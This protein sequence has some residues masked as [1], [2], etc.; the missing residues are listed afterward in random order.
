MTPTIHA[1]ILLLQAEPGLVETLQS[2]ATAQT[3][4]AVGV[5]ILIVLGIV[6]SVMFAWTL[7]NVIRFMRVI[8]KDL[9]PRTEPLLEQATRLAES[10]N[11]IVDSV[12]QEAESVRETVEEL[13]QRVRTAADAAEQRVRKLAAVLEVVQEEA[14]S[15]LIEAAATARGAHVAARALRGE[16]DED[17]DRAAPET[18]EAADAGERQAS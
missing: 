3:V 7:R 2:I 11:D 6:T 17:A 5:S 9:A 13:N 1:A 10:A 16:E 15:L 8:R 4:I 14:E 18:D 12:R